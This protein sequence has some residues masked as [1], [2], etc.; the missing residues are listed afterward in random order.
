MGQYNLYESFLHGKQD[1]TLPDGSEG[2]TYLMGCVFVFLIIGLLKAT[3]MEELGL[4][5]GSFL[6]VVFVSL[7]VV[8]HILS[9]A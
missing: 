2:F 5:I 1:A 7:L 9:W 8:Y 4:I 6:I 3:M